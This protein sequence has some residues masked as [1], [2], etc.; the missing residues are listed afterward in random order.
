MKRNREQKAERKMEAWELR[1]R[2]RTYREIGA[3][4]GV[5]HVTAERWVKECLEQK[6]LPLASEVRKQEL[7]R[8]TRYLDVLDHKIE[9]GD[10]AAVA[11]AV[12][13]SESIRKMLGADLPVVANAVVDQATHTELEIMTL[14]QQVQRRNQE[15]LERVSRGPVAAIEGELVSE[16]EVVD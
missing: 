14:I 7:D 12:K 15:A 10:I 11:L 13:V 1:L 5:S 9:C 3:A 6:S 4:L 8:L 16:A 2:G